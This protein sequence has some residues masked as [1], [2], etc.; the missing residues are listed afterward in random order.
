[1]QVKTFPLG[2][3][4]TN[5]YLLVEG[6]RAV[7]VDV[8][9]APSAMLRYIADKGLTLERILLT[10]LHFDH[11]LG[12]AAL[13]EATGAP[14]SASAGDADL[15]QSELGRGG[16]MGMPAVSDFPL[17]T[18]APGETTLLGQ[19]MTIFHTPGHTPGSLSYYFPQA[20]ALFS[21]DLV[22]YRSVG[23]SDF[24]GGSSQDL[25]N[26]IRDTVLTLPPETVIYPGHGPDT[27]VGQEALHNPFLSDFAR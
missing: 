23:R 13:H 24:P 2:P 26:A 11:T 18:I 6:D 27:N 12:V 25:L 8:G 21:G 10:H 16:F 19:P 3:L 20:K 9:G 7:A 17:E 4:E 1:M 5:S 14:V 15:L 22:F